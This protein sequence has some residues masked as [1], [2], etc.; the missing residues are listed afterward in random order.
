MST[1]R[2]LLSESLSPNSINLHMVSRQRDEALMEIVNLIPE[3]ANRPDAKETLF[4]ALK[5]REQLHSTGIGDG[6]ALPHSR[7]GL[8]GLVNRPCIV[9]GRH[10]HGV[11]FGSIDNLPARLF[12]LLV[13]PSVTQHLSILARISRLMRD[14]RLRKELLAADKPERI[15]E[16][17]REA[18]ANI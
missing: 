5:E 11:P 1:G 2:F 14:S 7:N 15:I 9:F 12:F 17:I 16:L 3:L 4:Q 13:A 6:V 18:E 8:V 10:T